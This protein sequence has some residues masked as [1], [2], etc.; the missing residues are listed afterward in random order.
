[1]FTKARHV[2]LKVAGAHGG[3]AEFV[4]LFSP[5][6]R[7]QAAL[8]AFD[9]AARV[10]GDGRRLAVS[11][12]R[13]RAGPANL[14]GEARLSLDGAKPRLDAV[15]TGNEIV[16][17]SFLPAKRQAAAAPDVVPAFYGEG[18]VQLA[19]A[20]NAADERWSQEPLDL[21]WLNGFDAEVKLTAPALTYE[22]YRLD[23]AALTLL[24]ADGAMA[25]QP[26]TGTL[27]GGGLNLRGGLGA[28][29]QASLLLDVAGAQMRQALLKAAAMDI[30]GGTL[31]TNMRLN[32][33][34]H[35]V[36]D[37]IARLDGQAKLEVHDGAVNGFDLQ[38]VNQRLNNID[39]PASLLS[40][41]Q[42]GLTGGQTRFSALTGTFKVDKGVVITRDLALQAEGGTAQAVATVNL[43][44]Y[45]IDSRTEFRLA[46]HPAAPPLVLRLQGS[47]ENP[48]KV[49]DINALQSWLVERGVGR[50]LKGKGG[51]VGRL[52][53]GVLGGQAAPAAEGQAPAAQPA[54]PQRI[55]PKDV[56]QGILKGLQQPRQ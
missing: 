44:A 19:A 26:L 49:F 7:P 48:R 56:L 37:L 36:H 10:Q 15:L 39:N 52:L 32:S 16:V 8:G 45:T 27:F 13:L 38:A 2:D 33:V 20:T 9:L 24:V 53:E 42:A 46:E 34:G 18:E 31:A 50:L 3:M 6:Y 11:D 21:D 1:P 51:D 40:L 47:L 17:D 54:D 23:N 25:L 43:P 12:L 5:H 14:A 28:D 41:V 22:Q 29:G 55:K 35:T 4:R 30:A